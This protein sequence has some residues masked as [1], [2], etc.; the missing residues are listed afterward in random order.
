LARTFYSC[1]WRA[2]DFRLDLDPDL[3]VDACLLTGVGRAGD[4]RLD[5]MFSFYIA[6]RVGLEGDFYL[7]PFFDLEFDLD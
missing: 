3:D 2:G 6:D 4:R 1:I 5:L 7:D